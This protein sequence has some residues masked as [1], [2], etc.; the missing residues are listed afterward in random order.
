MDEQRRRI[1]AIDRLL[2]RTLKERVEIGKEIARI[3]S[4][5]G[6][7]IEDKAQE[8]KVLDRVAEYAE[9]QI[10]EDCTEEMRQVFE[11]VIELTKSEMKN[12]T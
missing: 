2:I 3:K 6:L 5:S 1:K 9:E 11:K 4:D 10:S 8:Q 12:D 7:P